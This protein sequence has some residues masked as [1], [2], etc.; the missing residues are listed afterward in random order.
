MKK[1]MNNIYPKIVYVII[2]SFLLSSCSTTVRMST[3]FKEKRKTMVAYV[4]MPCE[5][6]IELRKVNGANERLYEME[7]NSCYTIRSTVSVELAKKGF[8]RVAFI[9]IDTSTLND[10]LKFKY[11]SIQE[12]IDRA[13]TEMY[14][15]PKQSYSKAY[16]INS[17]IGKDVN[18]FADYYKADLLVFSKMIGFKNSPGE[19]IMNA[20]K[21][22]LIGVF[23]LGN[24]IPIFDSEGGL[25][26]IAIVDGNN[27]E[28]LWANFVNLNGIIDV[29]G[30]DPGL[31]RLFEGLPDPPK[32]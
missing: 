8:E 10:D 21:S 19:N 6:D 25:I 13:I 18:F 22:V 26:Y 12:D 29:Q 32:K 17:S 2:L 23:T 16:H 14:T 9:D 30:I 11:N 1:A 15:R 20:G 31:K 4:Q 24:F 28:I 7:N 5:A 3:N 27:G